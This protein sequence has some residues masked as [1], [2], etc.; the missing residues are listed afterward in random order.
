MNFYGVKLFEIPIYRCSPEEYSKEEAV[1]KERA[2]LAHKRL[3]P[4]AHFNY[5]TWRGYRYNEVIGWIVIFA[6]NRRVR[7]EYWFIR[8]KVMKGL[9][10]KQF[11]LKNK[12]FEFRIK[13]NMET[14]QDIFKRLKAKILSISKEWQF[15]KYHFDLECFDNIGSSLDWRNLLH[16]TLS[17]NR[18]R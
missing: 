13:D 6:Y 17:S 18:K 8:Q 14:S 16:L 12:L 2:L 5:V 4:D 15:S 10:R 11:E 9:T 1:R 3:C 7:A